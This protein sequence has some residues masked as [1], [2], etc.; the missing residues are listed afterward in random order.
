MNAASLLG[1]GAIRKDLPRRLR[2]FLG[3]ILALIA[4]SRI[5]L[6]VHTP[7]DILVGVF[8][9]LLFMW[10]TTKLIQSIDG[11]ADRE[12]MVMIIGIGIAAAVAVY[13]ATKTYPEDYDAAG[14]LLVDGA[15]MAADTYKGVGWCI[16]FLAG[17]VLEKRQIGFSTDVPMMTRITR[18]V[19]GL[20]GYYAVSLILITLLKKWIPGPSGTVL[21]CFLQMF[22]VSYIFPWCTKL[23]EKQSCVDLSCFR[24]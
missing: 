16:G 4:F 21:T 12:I 22:Y 8:A 10:L 20:F 9:G 5:Y 6:G 15:K 19:T 3:V 23:A 7:Q 17:W 13:A 24:G 18:L 2:V 14:K 1:G 11:R